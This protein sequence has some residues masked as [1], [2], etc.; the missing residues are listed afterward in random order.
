MEL[1]AKVKEVTQAFRIRNRSA[2][3]NRSP[4]EQN[5]ANNNPPNVMQDSSEAIR[6]LDL[7]RFSL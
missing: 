7:G 6:E 2:N 1:E 4:P 3:K 5:K